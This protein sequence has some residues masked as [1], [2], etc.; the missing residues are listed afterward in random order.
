M[1]NVF[2]SN[3]QIVQWW[4]AKIAMVVHAL[5]ATK[6]IIWHNLKVFYMKNFLNFKKI[7]LLI[8]INEYISTNNH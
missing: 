6:D 8:F 1:D 4:I 7:C 5:N 2:S 3:N